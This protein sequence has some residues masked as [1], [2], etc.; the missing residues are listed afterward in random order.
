MGGLGIKPCD[1]W[2][3][4]ENFIKDMGEKPKGLTLDR[5]EGNKGYYKENCRWTNLFIQSAN[6]YKRKN[7]ASKYKG[8]SKDGDY[9][10]A[11]ITHHHNKINIGSYDTEEDAAKAYNE[12]ALQLR[13][14][15]AIVNKI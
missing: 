7:T 14:S 3:I 2:L 13:G 8:V 15:S 12:M 9:W 6:K 4:F 10:R 5:I 11:R 1:S